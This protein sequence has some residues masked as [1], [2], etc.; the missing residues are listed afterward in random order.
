MGVVCLMLLLSIGALSCGLSLNASIT[1]VY[2]QASAYPFTYHQNEPISEEDMKN[3]LILSDV[4]YY[5]Y[6]HNI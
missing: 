6:S 1:K 5:K 4:D 2:E 3:L